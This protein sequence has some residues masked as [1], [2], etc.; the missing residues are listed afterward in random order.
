MPDSENPPGEKIVT[1]YYDKNTETGI[2]KTIIE[3]YNPS[4]P[5]EK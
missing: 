3:R 2:I 5:D 4:N 1:I